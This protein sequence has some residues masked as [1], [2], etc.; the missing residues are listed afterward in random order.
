MTERDLSDIVW[1]DEARRRVDNA[2]A[3]V[4]PGI[5]KLMPIRARERGRTVITSE[6]LTEIRNESMLR[7]A[8]CI[9]GFGFE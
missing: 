3:F 2:P 5:L 9:R 6:F 7:V 1:T 8:K 4:R